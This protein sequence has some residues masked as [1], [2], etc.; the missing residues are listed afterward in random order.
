MNADPASFDNSERARKRAM[1]MFAGRIL[2]IE[3]CEGFT[4]SEFVDRNS[5]DGLVKVRYA[6]LRAFFV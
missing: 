1:L 5:T 2:E 6:A 4:L 3:G